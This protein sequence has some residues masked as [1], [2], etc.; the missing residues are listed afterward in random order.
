MPA[1]GGVVD[2]AIVSMRPIDGIPTSRQPSA[3]VSTTTTTVPDDRE[4][5][6]VDL[7]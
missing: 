7:C 6:K 1:T 2:S 5:F 4:I 3:G